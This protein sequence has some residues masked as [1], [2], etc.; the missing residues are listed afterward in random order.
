MTL[1]Y[2]VLRI[3]VIFDNTN[4]VWSLSK[5]YKRAHSFKKNQSVVKMWPWLSKSTPGASLYIYMTG[6]TGESLTPGHSHN[7]DVAWPLQLCG[8]ANLLIGSQWTI[9]YGANHRFA[10]S[11]SCEGFASKQHISVTLL[12]FHRFILATPSR[13]KASLHFTLEIHIDIT[14]TFISKHN[15]R[16]KDDMQVAYFTVRNLT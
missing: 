13:P 5:L 7:I 3:T 15:L 9:G 4:N 12:T 14:I 16:L 10:K 1:G 11:Q 8:H 2:T 6:N